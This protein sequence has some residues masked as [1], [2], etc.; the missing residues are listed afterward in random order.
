MAT[1]FR[2]VRIEVVEKEGARYL[3]LHRSNGEIVEK[4]IDPKSKASRKPRGARQ[5]VRT[6]KDRTRKKRF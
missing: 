4:K 5:K 1:M 2:T 6:I 3:I